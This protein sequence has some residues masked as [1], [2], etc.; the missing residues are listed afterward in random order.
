MKLKGFGAIALLLAGCGTPI[1]QNTAEAPVAEG[2]ATP[3][4]VIAPPVVPPRQSIPEIADVRVQPA[5][6]A[7]APAATK[8]SGTLGQT[9]ASLGDARQSG[10]WLKTPLIKTAQKGQVRFGGKTVDVELFPLEGP[11]TAG[12]RISLQA[13]QA[14][15]APLTGL[16]EI[17]VIAL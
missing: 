7:V 11:E 6:T 3:D 13:I 10:L 8:Q 9:I 4:E 17:D 12:S 2:P 14:L 1:F 5:D 15:G 16:L